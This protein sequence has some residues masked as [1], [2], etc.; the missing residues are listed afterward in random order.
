MR[1]Q[2]VTIH[3]SEHRRFEFTLY[4]DGDVSYGEYVDCCKCTECDG[5]ECAELCGDEVADRFIV[6]IN[7]DWR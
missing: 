4:D 5:C 7:T 6:N 2:T 1:K 3:L